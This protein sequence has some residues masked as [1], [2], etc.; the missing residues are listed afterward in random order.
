MPE[1]KSRA[2]LLRFQETGFTVRSLNPKQLL[3]DVG[4][5]HRLIN[6]SFA[7]PQNT[8]FAP[9]DME[10]FLA[11]LGVSPEA[12]NSLT[13]DPDWVKLCF[14]AD[15]IPAGFILMTRE[16]ELASIKTLCVAP[17]YRGDGVGGALVATAH[18]LAHAASMTWVAH[19]LMTDVGPSMSIT[20]AGQHEV[21]RRYAMFECEL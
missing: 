2:K 8:M 14:A 1:E 17:E 7:P 6:H 9:I 5:I 16:G 3:H 12:Q 21:L 18:R 13:L 15:G 4:L 11:V 20:A 10:E 19:T